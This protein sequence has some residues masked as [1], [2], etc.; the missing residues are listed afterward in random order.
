MALVVSGSKAHQK[1]SSRGYYSKPAGHDTCS[2]VLFAWSQVA[3][4]SR[5][6][7]TLMA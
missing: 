3:A 4:L 6:C 2:S 5:F 1:Q 7:M